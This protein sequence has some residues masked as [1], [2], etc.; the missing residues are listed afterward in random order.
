VLAIRIDIIPDT[1]EGDLDIAAA[2]RMMDR[3]VKLI[4]ITHV[5]TNSGLVGTPRK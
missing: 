3:D 1:Q 5:P 4:A 2:E